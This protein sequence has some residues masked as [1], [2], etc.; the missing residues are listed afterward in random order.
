[1]E[2]VGYRVGAVPFPSAGVGAPH[3]RDRLYWMADAGTERRNRVDALLRPKARGWKPGDILEAT[4]RSEA[5][6]MAD[7]KGGRRREERSDARRGDEGDRAEGIASRLVD[8]S[9]D[10][11]AGPTN[12]FW[13]DADWLGC[14][15]GKFRPVEPGTFP[16]ANGASA[17]VG[18]LRAYG[19]AIN[20]EAACIFVECAKNLSANTTF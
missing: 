15:D 16:L 11:G 2:G 4:G 13:R 6:G 1:L 12:G 17:R 14:R 5:R 18:R 9:C 19:N 8:G 10:S 3:I 7:T 20:G